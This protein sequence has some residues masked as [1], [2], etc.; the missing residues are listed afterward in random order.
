VKSAILETKKQ[1]G[2]PSK[3]IPLL[4]Q[5]AITKTVGYNSPHEETPLISSANVE[6]NITF[7]Y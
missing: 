1:T 5:L 2:K 7:L 3:P 6:Q 4:R